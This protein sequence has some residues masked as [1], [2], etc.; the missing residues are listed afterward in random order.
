MNT[1]SHLQTWRTQAGSTLRVLIPRIA[2]ST[3]TATDGLVD[4]LLR[5]LGEQPPRALGRDPYVGLFGQKPVNELRQQAAAGVQ[6][7]LERLR[8]PS[9]LPMD[10]QADALIR[11]LKG[12]SITRPVGVYPYEGLFGYTQ[13]NISTLQLQLWRQQGGQHLR[14][15][16]AEI[17]DITPT[18]ADDLADSLLRALGRQPGRPSNRLP[19]QGVIVLP[20]SI[21]FPEFR[22]RAADA[23]QVFITNINSDRLGSTDAVV[24]DVIRKITT[25]RGL[26]QLPGRP[27]ERLPYQG[28]FPTIQE[29]T[30]SQLVQIAPTAQRSQLRKFLPHLNATLVEFNISTPLRKAHFLSQVAHESAN[31]NAVEEF[32]DGSDYEGRAD[33]GN[34]FAGDGRRYKGRGLIQITGRFNYRQCGDALGVDLVQQPTLLVTDVLACRS[35]GWYWDSRQINVWADRD[36]VEQVTLMINGGYNGLDDRKAKLTA[37]KRAFGI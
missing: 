25:L 26:N 4:D 3:L 12:F 13:V 19:Y 30:E 23:L 11:S 29:V 31:F 32:A 17:P 34:F 37:A 24:D 35:A 33:L 8:L 20:D 22:R 2:S 6:V 28:L 36:N 5:A 15:L 16:V 14:R 21:P 10:E 1:S 7:Y 18:A 27:V 9:I